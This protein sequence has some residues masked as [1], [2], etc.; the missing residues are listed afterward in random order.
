MKRKTN[1]R[2]FFFIAAIIILLVPLV[3]S[4]LMERSWMDIGTQ[5]AESWMSF[6]GGYLG[7]ILGIAGAI[8]ATTIQIQSQTDQIVM[9]ASKNDEFERQRI[10]SSLIIDKNDV[11]Y[12]KILDLKSNFTILT[13]SFHNELTKI[14]KPILSGEFERIT[15]PS[16]NLNETTFHTIESLCIGIQ[17]YQIFIKDNTEYD[18]KISTLIKDIQA[19]MI[20]IEHPFIGDKNYDNES[21]ESLR[22][23]LVNGYIY[24]FD[25]FTEIESLYIRHMLILTESI[26]IKREET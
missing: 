11:L 14:V 25:C 21:I 3:V 19:L 12:Q 10:Y 6:W 8:I 9:A 26:L 7:A 20:S 24:I 2:L 22:S 4:Y 16:L 23:E 17:S 5:K 13:D 18:Q 1:N 15:N